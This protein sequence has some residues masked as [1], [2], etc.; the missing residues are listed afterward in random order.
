[1]KKLVYGVAIVSMALCCAILAGCG[2]NPREA[3][4]RDIRSAMQHFGYS[5]QEINEGIGV[6]Y[7][8]V[9]SLEEMF[10]DNASM[11]MKFGVE[12]IKGLQLPDDKKAII[13]D[14]GRRAFKPGASEVPR[15]VADL[16]GGNKVNRILTLVEVVR[17]LKEGD[18]EY[19][20]VF[21]KLKKVEEL[22]KTC[23]ARSKKITELIGFDYWSTGDM[24]SGTK[25]HL[26][27]IAREI[28]T[29]EDLLK[30]SG[31]KP[32]MMAKAAKFTNQ[33]AG[34]DV[35]GS[36]RDLIG[37]CLKN[38]NS[39]GIKGVTELG[40]KQVVDALSSALA[41]VEREEAQNDEGTNHAISELLDN[42]LIIRL[43]FKGCSEKDCNDL[44]SAYM[45]EFK[46]LPV[47][48]RLETAR[49]RIAEAIRKYNL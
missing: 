45:E 25:N 6:Y 16:A 17:L 31:L 29:V 26:E 10:L 35:R 47:E 42:E 4:K 43:R 37:N 40:L 48:R 14:I 32:G 41:Q 23:Q 13:M 33:F 49:K 30:D 7:A 44:K 36:F 5:D 3:L 8:D 22:R 38:P 39:P 21:P 12:A 18:N 28:S 9:D 11:S 15:D 24:K 1:M 27:A 34:L 46:A 20:G 19:C 2:E